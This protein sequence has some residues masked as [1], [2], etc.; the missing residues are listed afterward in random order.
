MNILIENGSNQLDNL[1]DIA[2]LQVCVE[3]LR[4]QWPEATLRVITRDPAGL[5]NHVPN[6]APV[7]IEYP[8]AWS[9]LRAAIA[10]PLPKTLRKLISRLEARAARRLPAAY[11]DLL[12]QSVTAA[13][14]L[15]HSGAGILADPFPAAAARRMALLAEAADQG[16]PTAMFSQGIGPLTVPELKRAAEAVLPRLSLLCARDM[17]SAVFLTRTLGMDPARVRFTG[18]DALAVGYLSRPAELGWNLA[19]NARRSAYSNIRRAD[20]RW[21]ALQLGDIRQQLLGDEAKVVPVAIHQLDRRPTQQL[22]QAIPEDRRLAWHSMDAPS[23][24]AAVGGCRLVVCTSYHAAVLA[25]A[26]GIPA[27]C[28]YRTAYYRAKFNGLCDQFPDACRRVNLADPQARKQLNEFATDLLSRAEEA[29][30]SALRST[31]DQIERSEDA[32]E[33]L[34]TRILDP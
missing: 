32:Y 9:V 11:R 28:L 20:L 27:I 29:R 2:M 3:R 14:L 15:V 5:G 8:A 21:I 30:A 24:V 6:V 23:M 12:T 7:S 16:I 34:L 26:Q 1:G 4:H 10:A 25:L 19:V 17:E 22:T 33:R 13:D 31:A 18:D